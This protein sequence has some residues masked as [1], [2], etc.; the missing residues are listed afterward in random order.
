MSDK[1]REF[2]D[3]WVENSIHAVNSTRMR[4]HRRMWRNSRGVSSRL[5]RGK[6]FRRPTCRL[7]LA[8]SPPISKNF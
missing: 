4:A 3:F 1:A 6:A 7:R 8:T 2:I 5:P